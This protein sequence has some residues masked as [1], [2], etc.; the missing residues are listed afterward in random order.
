MITVNL[1]PTLTL[2]LTLTL[3]LIAV[4]AAPQV[5]WTICQILGLDCSQLTA[6]TAGENAK[7]TVPLPTTRGTGTN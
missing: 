6:A 3:I 7:Y 5:A 2:T 1:T 4:I